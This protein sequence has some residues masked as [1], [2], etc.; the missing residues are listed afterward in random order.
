MVDEL[1]EDYLGHFCEWKG[2]EEGPS[3]FLDHS[4]P[5]LDLEDVL[6]CCRGVDVDPR[7]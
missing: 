2:V 3:S 4:N 1:D 5:P 6:F 7:Y